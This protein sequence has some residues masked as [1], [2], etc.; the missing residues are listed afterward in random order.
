MTQVVRKQPVCPDCD[1]KMVK[2]SIALEGENDQPGT[3][4]VIWLCGCKTAG[5]VKQV[6]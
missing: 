3:W 1:E 4:L 2:A 6:A 5:P